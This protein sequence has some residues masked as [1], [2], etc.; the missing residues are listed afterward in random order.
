[1]QVAEIAHHFAEP[2]Q[3][4]RPLGFREPLDLVGRG[5]VSEGMIVRWGG[6]ERHGWRVVR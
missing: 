3:V 1:M 4:E 6:L 2:A 5:R